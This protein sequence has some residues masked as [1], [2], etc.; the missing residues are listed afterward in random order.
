MLRKKIPFGVIH[1]DL[2]FCLDL[3]DKEGWLSAHRIEQAI[4]DTYWRAVNTLEVPPQ[5]AINS[6]AIGA[7]LDGGVNA[8]Y[9]VR[10]FPLLLKRMS[11][12]SWCE[13]GKD[14][15]DA[16]HRVAGGERSGVP[17]G[18]PAGGGG[19]GRLR[20][21]HHLGS[22]LINRVPDRPCL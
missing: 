21:S 16:L 15:V 12:A 19:E 3:D 18:S 22:V 20:R 14:C 4:V 8:P 1:W 9:D 13:K 11:E 2:A 10:G 6:L 5:T 17:R 7:D